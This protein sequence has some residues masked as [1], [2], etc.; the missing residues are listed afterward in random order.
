MKKLLCFFYIIP[1]LLF[2]SSCFAQSQTPAWLFPIMFKDGNDER[3]TIYIGYDTAAQYSSGIDTAFGEKYI[4]IDTTRFN[5]GIEISADSAFKY[6]IMKQPIAAQIR[7]YKGIMPLTMYWYDTLFYNDSL[8][9]P[10]L[11]PKPRARGDLACGD[12]NPN[13]FNCPLNDA[14]VLTDMPDSLPFIPFFTYSDSIVFTGDSTQPGISVGG[15]LLLIKPFNSSQTVGTISE[16]KETEDVD[17]FPNP[18]SSSFIL[19]S[20]YVLIKYYK[21]YNI[22]GEQLFSESMKTPLQET[23]INV[24]KNLDGIY[25]IE[26]E[27]TKNKTIKKF[28]VIK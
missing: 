24:E 23:K 8:P 19:K 21:I 4:K 7:F 6:D 15:F 26:I 12:G 11:S 5:A 16:S 22:L 14:I 18:S 13:Y 27:T 3:D 17:L 1:S 28:I 25:F 20:K 9:F 2:I 10:N